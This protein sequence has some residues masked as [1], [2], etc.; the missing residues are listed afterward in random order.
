MLTWKLIR[1]KRQTL[2]QQ[3]ITYGLSL[4]IIIIISVCWLVYSNYCYYEESRSLYIEKEALKIQRI[5]DERITYTE[6]MLQF[7]GTKI[8]EN[9]DHSEYAIA[10][11]IQAH[12]ETFRDETLLGIWL[13]T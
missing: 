7:I 5:F 9:R 8:R 1:S 4:V 6:H 11:T 3:Y 10:R 12:K 13:V 2:A